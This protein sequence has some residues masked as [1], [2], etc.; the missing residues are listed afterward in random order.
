MTDRIDDST[1]ADLADG[2]LGGPEWEAR[3]AERPELRAEVELAR[4]VRALMEELR[5]AQI[6]VP[7]GFEARLLARVR[8]DAALRDLLDLGLAGLGRALVELLNALLSLLPSA[9]PAPA[10]A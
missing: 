4:R 7:E 6:E 2:T 9:T 5:S 3:L 10:A 8:E 1:L